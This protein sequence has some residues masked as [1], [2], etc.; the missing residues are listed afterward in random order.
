MVLMRILILFCLK[1]YINIY[2]I[3]EEML[4]LDLY[5]YWENK[6]YCVRLRNCCCLKEYVVILL[7]RMI[8]LMLLKIKFMDMVKGMCFWFRRMKNKV[9]FINWNIWNLFESDLYVYNF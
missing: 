4:I 9:N 3:Y 5:M 2:I 6:K 8:I 1:Y 7:R